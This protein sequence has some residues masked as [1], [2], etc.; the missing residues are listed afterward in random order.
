MGIFDNLFQAKLLSP[1]P[2]PPRDPS[3]LEKLVSG[4]NPFNGK[5][6]LGNRPG[7]FPQNPMNIAQAQ[8]AEPSPIPTPAPTPAA[9]KEALRQ[10]VLPQKSDYMDVLKKYTAPP[11]GELQSYIDQKFPEDSK[12]ARA[13]FTEE[14]QNGR[15]P[16]NL[17]GYP[18]FGATQVALP[19]HSKEIPGVTNQE[20]VQ[21]LLDYKN[22]LDL[23]RQIYDQR[24][25]SGEPGFNAWEAYT[26]GRYKKNL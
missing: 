12:T 1:V 15:M 17:Q 9:I 18:A 6:F 21:W 4:Q 5:V 2:D 10:V 13:V 11:L 20:K 7:Y 23:A 24:A 26:T 3:F 25:K 16:Q 19:Y 8:A 22:N 14:S